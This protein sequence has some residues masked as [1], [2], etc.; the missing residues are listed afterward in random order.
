MTGRDADYPAA[1]SMDVAWYAV[2]RDG[3]IAVFQSGEDGAVPAGAH[4]EEFYGAATLG[5]IEAVAPASEP[6]HSL[7]GRTGLHQEWSRHAP[8]PL[9]GHSPPVLFR[10]E[11]RGG[12]VLHQE[13][14]APGPAAVEPTPIL[15]FVTSLD[16]LGDEI[17]RGEALPVPADD[18]PAVLFRSITR[19]TFERLHDTGVCLGCSDLVADDESPERVGLFHYEHP[20]DLCLSEPYGRRGRPRH[21]LRIDHLPA[22]LG[23]LIAQVRFGTICFAESDRIQPVEHARCESYQAAF[24]STDGVTVRPIPGKED[25]FRKEYETYASLAPGLKVDPSPP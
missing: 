23:G 1:H 3:H 17:A 11:S 20:D 5:R 15:M 9:D 16:T 2:D 4:A 14:I 25:E 10:I 24:L 6:I 8:P 21:P 13:E 12:I 19:S 7:R 22:D 18:A